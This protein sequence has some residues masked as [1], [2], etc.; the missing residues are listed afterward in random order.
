ML[1]LSGYVGGFWNVGIR[2]CQQSETKM[3][4]RSSYTD[5]NE[6]WK[7]S[8]ILSVNLSESEWT[9]NTHK[10][11]SKLIESV[12]LW[13]ILTYFLDLKGIWRRFS[14]L[15]Y[16]F[17]WNYLQSIRTKVFYRTLISALRPSVLYE[18]RRVLYGSSVNQKQPLPNFGSRH[19]IL[20]FT[21]IR[22]ETVT[23]IYVIEILW[24]S[25]LL[26]YRKDI[27]LENLILSKLS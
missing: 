11:F 6:L 7:P 9:I 27:I 20:L 4:L 24:N 26:W 8:K 16:F 15:C 5:I 21:N 18:T 22:C 12:S 19:T 13:K 25:L 1:R 2:L 3:C 14:A 17:A 10:K 23:S